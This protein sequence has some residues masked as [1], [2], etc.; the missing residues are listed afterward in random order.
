MRGIA[1]AHAG[2]GRVWHALAQRIVESEDPFALVTQSVHRLGFVHAKVQGRSEDVVWM[3]RAAKEAGD[4]VL[5]HKNHPKHDRHV[6]HVD[7]IGERRD[8]GDKL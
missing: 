1:Y 8:H 3:P 6:D 4:V 2:V 5:A 7:A